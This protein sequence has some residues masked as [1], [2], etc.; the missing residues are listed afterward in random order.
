MS[1]SKIS[2]L[3]DSQRYF[4]LAID[5][6]S[7]GELQGYLYHDCRK[8]AIHFNNVVNLVLIMEETFELLKSPTKSMEQR[9]FKIARK[10]G[11]SEADSV[12]LEPISASQVPEGQL[13]T[14]EMRVTQRQHAS[15][16]G[17]LRWKGSDKVE[18]F[19]SFLQFLIMVHEKISDGSDK[20]IFPSTN[21]MFRIA[22]DEYKG[23]TMQGRMYQSHYI[24]KWEFGSVMDLA[25]LMK[26]SL[27]EGRKLREGIISPIDRGQTLNIYKPMG[28]QATFIINILFE[29]YGTWQGT[30]LMRD[31]MEKVNFRSFLELI[32]LMDT[33][34]AGWD[35]WNRYHAEDE[36]IIEDVSM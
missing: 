6:F 9:L 25:F 32:M 12:V 35:A 23:A 33:A 28:L 13:A 19:E 30:V 26:Y 36:E 29:E 17:N 21:N 5:S 7:E 34:L 11:R 3:T 14:L 4:T 15:W 10:W 24:E 1:I 31:T 2:T 18:N 20:G 8:S 27:E 16:Q 22:V